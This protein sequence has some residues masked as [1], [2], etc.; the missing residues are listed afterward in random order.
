[1]HAVDEDEAVDY[2]ALPE[3]YNRATHMMAGAMAG[4]AEHALIYPIDTIKV[5]RELYLWRLNRARA[6][7]C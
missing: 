2:E 7:K 6:A 3:H 5:G 4:V 1:M